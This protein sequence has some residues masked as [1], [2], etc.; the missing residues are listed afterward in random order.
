[1][2]A[3]NY[4]LSA[5]IVRLALPI[6]GLLFFSVVPA[7][8][9][10]AADNRI[11]TELLTQYT[12]NGI[13]DYAGF[14]KEEARLDAYLDVLAG[15]DPNALARDDRFAFYANAYNAWTIKLILTGYPGVKSIKDLGSFFKSPWKKKFVKLGG[16]VIS[17]DHIEHDILR[18]QF[19]D[20]R[21]H[22]AVNCAS[23]SC[24]P[25]WGKPFTGSHLDVQ[26]DAAARNFINNPGFNRLEGSTLYVSRIFKWFSEDFDDD[27]IGF[28]EKYATG[29]L[30]SKIQANR[31]SLE[32]EYLDYDWSL[33]GR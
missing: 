23:K 30:R 22:M 26:L 33:N 2:P 12:H 3:K 28:F 18:P 25:L 4:Y 15:V 13:V 20:P 24:P 17:L 10:A 11:F 6:V 29:K 1:M 27:I 19:K 31:A 8:A 16:A 21:V 14:K 9:G 5:G 32:V 7:Q